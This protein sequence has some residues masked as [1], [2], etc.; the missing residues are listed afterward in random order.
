VCFMVFHGIKDLLAIG[1]PLR[2]FQSL[3]ESLVKLRIAGV[4]SNRESSL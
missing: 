1:G 4:G 2:F 3:F